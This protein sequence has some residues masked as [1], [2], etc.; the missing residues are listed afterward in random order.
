MPCNDCQ[1]FPEHVC[2]IQASVHVYLCSRDWRWRPYSGILASLFP[3]P[4]W[5]LPVSK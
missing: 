4:R 2:L 1:G 3:A 5:E